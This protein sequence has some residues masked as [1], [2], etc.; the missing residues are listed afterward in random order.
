MLLKETGLDFE[1]QVKPTAED[2]PEGLQREEIA[3]YVSRKKAEAFDLSEYGENTLL[4]T[5]DTIVW[6]NGECIGKPGDE[7]EA[8]Q[9]LSKLSGNMH[10]VSTGVCL[11]SLNKY[12]EFYVNTDVY[13]R[14]LKDEEIAYYVE[15]WRPFDKAGAYGI[16][17]WI[18]YVG[19]DRIEGSYFNVMGLPVQRLYCELRSFVAQ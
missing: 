15:T 17:E 4:I 19:V 5:A 1:I 8:V 18:G 14:K 2:Y 7:K 16:Q 9:M 13:F 12:R 11:V 10:T 3:L 6:L